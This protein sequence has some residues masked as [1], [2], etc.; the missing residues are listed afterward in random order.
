VLQAKVGSA[1]GSLKPPG[2]EYAEH[3]VCCLQHTLLNSASLLGSTWV[4]AIAG[5][6]TVPVGHVLLTELL[7][8][9][10]Q[11]PV[12]RLCRYDPSVAHL[13]ALPSSHDLAG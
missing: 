1:A 12:M 11:V 4:V 10:K 2:H 6:R 13:Q 9:W 5:L 7:R 3:V 8:E